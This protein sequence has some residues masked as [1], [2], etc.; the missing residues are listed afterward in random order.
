[1]AIVFIKNSLWHFGGKLTGGAVY[2]RDYRY[3]ADQGVGKSR[4]GKPG[5]QDRP[6]QELI[7]MLKKTIDA[8]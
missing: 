2:F 1:M 4:C 6:E 7:S 5:F 3:A 8:Q